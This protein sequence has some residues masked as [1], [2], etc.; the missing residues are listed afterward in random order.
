VVIGNTAVQGLLH[1]GVAKAP[2]YNVYRSQHG[3]FVV[4]SKDGR[5]PAVVLLGGLNGGLR[6]S[7]R[8]PLGQNAYVAK[9]ESDACLF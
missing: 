7:I 2:L 6:S 3:F 9:E 4:N 8:G 5:G 1:M